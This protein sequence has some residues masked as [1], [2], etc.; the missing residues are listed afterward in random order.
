[1]FETRF[2]FF[3][4]CLEV[5]QELILPVIDILQNAG[6]NLV[7]GTRSESGNCHIRPRKY[8][9]L[10]PGHPEVSRG[11]HCQSAGSPKLLAPCNAYCQ[12][13]LADATCTSPPWWTRHGLMQVLHCDRHCE[14]NWKLETI[15]GQPLRIFWGGH[16]FVL[17]SSS[18]FKFL[19]N[20]FCG[21]EFSQV[22]R[23]D[24]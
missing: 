11:T 17:H 6:I 14:G 9:P 23:L 12:K 3:G 20:C 19:K 7:L 1:M 16:S 8:G 2:S 22:W 24:R 15:C 18:N 10:W 4:Q 13:P 21:N 5:L